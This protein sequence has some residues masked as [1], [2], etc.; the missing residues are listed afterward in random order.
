MQIESLYI[1]F[2]IINDQ[3]KGRC[4]TYFPIFPVSP[5]KNIDEI[6]NEAKSVQSAF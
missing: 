1:L 3:M 4:C 5:Q 2:V 6:Y